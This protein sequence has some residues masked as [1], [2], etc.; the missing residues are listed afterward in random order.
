MAPGALKGQ[1]CCKAKGP[2][3]SIPMADYQA[4]LQQQFDVVFVPR[5]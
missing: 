5:R 3:R 1:N 4:P 2:I